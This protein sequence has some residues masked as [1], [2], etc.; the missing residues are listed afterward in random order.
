MTNKKLTKS[1]MLDYIEKTGMII[2]F[3]RNYLMRTRDK[4]TITRYYE[5][6]KKFAEKNNLTI[7]IQ[8]VM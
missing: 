8:Q 4:A 5:D 3:D 1:T 6:A 2:N 7:D